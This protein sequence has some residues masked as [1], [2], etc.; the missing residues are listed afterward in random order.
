MAVELNPGVRVGL[1]LF[2]LAVAGGAI[3]FAWERAA[4]RA[5]PPESL[6]QLQ[7]R[8]AQEFVPAGSGRTPGEEAVLSR[9]LAHFP[10]YPRAK[11]RPEVLAADYLGPEAPMAVAWFA[12]QDTPEQVLAYYRGTLMDA[13]LPA[14]GERHGRN[15]G[16]VGYWS[17]S[18]KD[19]HL[20]SVLAQGGETYVFVSSGQVGPLLN[21][22]LP[23]PT[24]VPLPPG[25]EDP[26]VLTFRMEGATYY[27]VSGRVP[28]GLLAEVGTA[29]QAELK[30]KGWTVE[31]ASQEGTR[32]LGF[33]VSHQTQ[34]GQVMLRQPSLQPGVEFNLTL[35]ER[36]V[37]PP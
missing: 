15:G 32:E 29:Y 31:A 14:L 8:A 18:S 16:Y 7:A 19:V 13:G 10:P 22:S 25:V 12:T 4:Y 2:S 9:A 5:E 26:A 20:V 17:P 21:K 34:R 23:V 30:A 33:D 35:M 6:E 3:G 28:E 37:A 1:W 11:G 27:T 24:W 36:T